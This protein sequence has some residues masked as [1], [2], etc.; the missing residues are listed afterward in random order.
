GSTVNLNSVFFT[1][2]IGKTL[3]VDGGAVTDT[4]NSLLHSGETFTIQNAG[5]WDAVQEDL[6]GGTLTVTGTGSRFTSSSST[7][8]SSWAGLGLN[9]NFTT[10]GTG[11]FAGQ[12]NF[13]GGTYT[14]QMSFTNSVATF[15]AL[16]TVANTTVGGVTGAT[17]LSV[18]FASTL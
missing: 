9:V 6:T 18:A 3:T 13:G 16:T 15:G 14:N 7:F 5:H 17:T 10:F 2:A 1:L 4:R 8:V 12:V 11:S